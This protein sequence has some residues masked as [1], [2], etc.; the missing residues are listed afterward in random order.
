[1][2]ACAPGLPYPEH[3]TSASTPS[4]AQPGLDEAQLTLRYIPFEDVP[5]WG[6][7]DINGFLPA[8]LR[9]C[10]QLTDKDPETPIGDKERFGTVGDWLDICQELGGNMGAQE[11]VLRYF[12]ESKLRPY[13]VGN[14]DET[15]G[16]FTGYY[17][18][19]LKGSW[20]QSGTYTVPIYARPDDIVSVD[21]GTFRPEWQGQTL[22]G[23]MEGNSLV[24]YP[25]RAAISAGALNGRQ[26]EILWVN[27][28]IDAFFL[29][30]QGSGRVQMTDG[31]IVRVAYSG[32]NGHRYFPVGRELIAAG[33]ISQEDMSMQAIRAWMDVNP[34][35]A[36]QLMNLNPSYIF[37]RIS[38]ETDPVG[39]E[40]V[41]LT[42][43]RS[44]AVDDDFIPYG[45]PMLLDTL[46]PRDPDRKTPLQRLVVP[47]DT[48]S[49]IRGP[50]RGDFFWGF[51]REAA[52]AAGYMKEPGSYYM[53]L[54]RTRDPITDALLE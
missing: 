52:A 28:H 53:F 40:G 33:I 24:P 9:S 25:D 50:V 14:H 26:L 6:E 17:E 36:L 31:S 38:N 20:Q 43:G 19:E 49:A 7:V 12:F 4:L 45:L 10:A 34:A 39:A 3:D 48:G 27:S 30:I 47:Q 8:F 22:A 11:P 42:P 37:F 29:H 51:G 32:R 23:K 15:V 2:G 54:P 35:A 41:P 1:M 5:G 44:I 18:A 16:L 21:L 46:D 13:L